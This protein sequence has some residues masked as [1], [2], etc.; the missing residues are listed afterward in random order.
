MASVT[1]TN[2]WWALLISDS[3]PKQKYNHV[4]KVKYQL[5]LP[6][7]LEMFRASV[8]GIANGVPAKGS[9]EMWQPDCVQ[10]PR[11]PEKITT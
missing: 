5:S 7:I 11:G 9:A 1:L 2:A 3:A 8:G 4:T 10:K 6:L